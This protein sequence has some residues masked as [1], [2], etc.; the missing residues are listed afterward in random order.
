M[1][2]VSASKRL[3][4]NAQSVR[5]KLQQED[6]IAAAAAIIQDSAAIP[7][8]SAT[9]HIAQSEP[10]NTPKHELTDLKRIDQVRQLLHT[11]IQN[12]TAL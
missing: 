11:F 2:Q 8:P 3:R 9:L 5:D 4:S 1:R 10:A 7:Q 12:T 6:G